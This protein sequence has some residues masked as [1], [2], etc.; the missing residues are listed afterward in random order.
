MTRLELLLVSFRETRWGRREHDV[1]F[2]VNL[3]FCLF[4]TQT[5]GTPPRFIET[6]YFVS[7]RWTW[8]QSKVDESANAIR[9]KHA[10]KGEVFLWWA[11]G[12]SGNSNEADVNQWRQVWESKFPSFSPEAVKGRGRRKWKSFPA[13]PSPL[14]W[15]ILT[16]LL[17]IS[18]SHF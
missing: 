8:R 17:S 14:I 10:N 2:N 13:T 7:G 5:A 3:F 12:G 16:L 15:D 18:R 9:H 6:N 4:I 1:R 11:I